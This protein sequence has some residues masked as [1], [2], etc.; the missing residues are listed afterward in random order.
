M[1]YFYLN[2]AELWKSTCM[3]KFNG[4]TL[5]ASSVNLDSSA[6]IIAMWVSLLFFIYETFKKFRFGLF[7]SKNKVSLHLH[8]FFF[9]F[10]FFFFFLPFFPLQLFISLLF[11][12]YFLFFDSLFPPSLLSFRQF[13]N[14]AYNHV[15]CGWK[16][17]NNGQFMWMVC[18][19]A[20]QWVLSFLRKSSI[21]HS[22]VFG[23]SSYRTLC[24]IHR[25]LYLSG[26]DTILK[27]TWF[28]I[29][30]KIHWGPD[31]FFIV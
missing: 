18:L 7:S 5:T 28:Q 15:G 23:D 30:I 13:V 10:S 2:S 4:G 27:W 26:L 31:I 17:C 19:Y 29:Q 6:D 21:P 14:W 3:A 11:C 25:F 8:F 1:V 20:G 22:Y 24:N 16:I 9:V 12:F